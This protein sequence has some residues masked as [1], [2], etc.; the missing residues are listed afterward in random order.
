MVLPV[1][2]PDC[3]R[4]AACGGPTKPIERPL[5]YLVGS[6]TGQSVRVKPTAISVISPPSCWF[7]VPSTIGMV[8]LVERFRW[9]ALC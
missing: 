2:L 7:E 6:L 4:S 5:C 1:E 8:L 3:N 9:E